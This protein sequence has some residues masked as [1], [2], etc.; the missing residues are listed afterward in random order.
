MGFSGSE[1]GDEVGLRSGRRRLRLC[2]GD[3]D[4]Q[5]QGWGSCPPHMVLDP[6]RGSHLGS[7]TQTLE[8]GAQEGVLVLYSAV[9]AGAFLISLVSNA[10]L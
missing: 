5:Y 3:E 1:Q 6:T 9:T 10:T 8:G 2:E 4:V 7:D